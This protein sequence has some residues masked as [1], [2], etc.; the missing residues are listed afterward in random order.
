MSSAWISAYAPHLARIVSVTHPPHSK[1]RLM[2]ML[3]AYMDESSDER[4]EKVQCIAGL[5]APAA[6]WNCIWGEWAQLLLKHGITEY[7]AKECCAGEGE[8]DRFEPPEREDIHADFVNVILRSKQAIATATMIL[9]P[10]FPEYGD[11]LER[12]RILPQ[13]KAINGPLRDPYFMGF[14]HA[15]QEMARD[16]NVATLPANEKVAFMFDHHHLKGRAGALFH[17]LL[18]KE[19][20]YRDRLGACVFEDSKDFLPLQAADVI[21][22]EYRR[23]AQEVWLEKQEPRDVFVE[24]AAKFGGGWR[25]GRDEFQR[26]SSLLGPPPKKPYRVKA[27]AP[28]Q[29]PAEQQRREKIRKQRA[30]KRRFPRMAQ[31]LAWLR[32]KL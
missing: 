14:E 18:A 20:D 16:R 10:D 29:D 19:S 4:A 24:L 11:S 21:A 32:G 8:F 2:L 30:F 15:V 31:M 27:G 12:R 1:V 5:M 6:E 7:H 25:I 28:P 17:D 13:K 9:L 23:Y 3:N 22:Y 26:L